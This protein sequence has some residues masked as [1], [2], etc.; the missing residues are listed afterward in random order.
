MK[1][2]IETVINADTHHD[3]RKTKGRATVKAHPG[4]NDEPHYGVVVT[5]RSQ[6]GYAPGSRGYS[7]AGVTKFS[8]AEAR[9]LAQALLDAAAEVERN[10]F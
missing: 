8:P 1:T 7:P 9:R 6:Q 5:V 2:F 3:G 10:G 4:W